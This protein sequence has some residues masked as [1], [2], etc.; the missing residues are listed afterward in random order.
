[1]SQD[2]LNFC[3]KKGLL[4]DSSIL[5][6]LKE[7]DDVDSVK[8]VIEKIK[9][10]SQQRI[11]TKETFNKNS[12]KLSQLFSNLPE[13]NKKILQKLKI[14]LGL[15]IEISQEVICENIKDEENN[16]NEKDNYEIIN[17]QEDFSNNSN[18]KVISFDYSPS[19][20]LNV[21]DFVNYFRSRFEDMRK[22][23]QEHS[24]LDSLVS[25]NKM[26]G[27]KQNVSLIGL[28][29]DKRTTKN[30]NILLD[31]EDLT[32]TTRVLINKNKK[33]LYDKAQEITLDSVL[34]FKGSGN[35]EIFFVNDVIFPDA[36]LS[37]R[38]KSPNEEHA[39]FLGDTHIGSKKFMEENFLSF[40]NYINGNVPGTEEEVKK[41]KYL[42]FVGDLVAGVGNYPGQEYE[43]SLPDLESHF[44]KAAELLGKIRKD[45][46]II[47]SPGN[48]D[49]VRI[50]EPQPVLSEKYAWPLYNMENVIIT[51][52]PST[53]NIASDPNKGFKGFNVLMYHGF[54]YFY[55]TDNIYPLMMAE[56]KH[57]PEIILKYILKNRHLAP[58]HSSTQYFP[59][60]KDAHI[61]REVPDIILSGHIHKSA[62]SHYNNILCISVSGW[63]SMTDYMEKMGAKPDFCK[64]PLLNL[65]TRAIKILDF[66]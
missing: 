22:I 13:Q 16:I 50:M 11:I 56:A 52:N 9:E 60:E 46:T 45:I 6:A 3:M 23:L 24:E 36:V 59:S 4:V 58:T 12:D 44:E 43:I 47:I 33:E 28:V 42:F 14:R 65:K 61:I 55:Y 25:I 62:V 35:K 48:H 38:K 63:E 29:L 51:T 26:S 37:E 57:N 17:N 31:I 39:V 54:S 18:V 2:I 30:K 21:D 32:G 19:K 27:N 53:V 34:G 66:E 20:K 10:F 8:F 49:G 64:V 15:N 1:M 41:I 40:I 5:N 7:V